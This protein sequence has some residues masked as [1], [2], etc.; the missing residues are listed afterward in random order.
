MLGEFTQ[1]GGRD[2]E[3]FGRTFDR[4]AGNITEIG[5]LADFIAGTLPSLSHSERQAVLEQN[6][7]RTRLQFIHFSNSRA[8]WNCSSLRQKIQSQ[9]QGQLS[10]R[11]SASFI[12]ASS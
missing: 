12:C 9:V 7:A 10:Q 2:A 11:A 3:S 4:K 8:K 5:R 6:D 1:T